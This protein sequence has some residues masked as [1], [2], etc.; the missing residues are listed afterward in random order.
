VK[1]TEASSLREVEEIRTDVVALIRELDQLQREADLLDVR[2]D[3]DALELR[4]A[5]RT[6]VNDF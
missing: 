2:R 3:A 6:A 5:P 1:V 4:F